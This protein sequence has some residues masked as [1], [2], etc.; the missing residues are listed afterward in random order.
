M[1]KKKLVL[2]KFNY[3]LWNFE[4]KKI[5]LLQFANEKFLIFEKNSRQEVIL[6][7]LNFQLSR[8][9]L[10]F[11]IFLVKEYFYKKLIFIKKHQFYL[12]P[13]YF[14]PIL[15]YTNFI[16]HQNFW[17]FYSNFILHQNLIYTNFILHQFYFTPILIYTNFILHQFY[18]TSI[19][20]YTN[21]ILH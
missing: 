16:L 17:P 5:I 4:E 1:K 18:F 9:V 15:F 8:E 19:L 3:W 2:W 10:I 11:V 20:F 7:N 13:I 12:T 21:V 14:T 6:K